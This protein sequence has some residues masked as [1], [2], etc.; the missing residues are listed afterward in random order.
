MNHSPQVWEQ[1]GGPSSTRVLIL[2]TVREHVTGIPQ[3]QFFFVSWTALYYKEAD[4][5]RQHIPCSMSNNFH[6]C[7]PKRC[8]DINLEHGRRKH[9]TLH[10]VSS[11]MSD[12]GGTIHDSNS[13][14][15]DQS[16]SSFFQV[17]LTL[18]FGNTVS[19]SFCLSSLGCNGVLCC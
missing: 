13:F 3:I 18:S 12:G 16:C 7:S 14:L 4:I 1:Y 5:Y 8:T 10:S 19:L 9:S 11:G 2:P 6:L 17:T 15:I